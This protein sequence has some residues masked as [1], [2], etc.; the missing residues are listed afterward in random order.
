VVL[1]LDG[2]PLAGPIEAAKTGDWQAWKTVTA[3]RIELPEGEHTLRV[4][5]E[6]PGLNLNWIEV[7]APQ[8]RR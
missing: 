3:R 2:N 8:R 6:R 5:M 7:R 4:R 1:E